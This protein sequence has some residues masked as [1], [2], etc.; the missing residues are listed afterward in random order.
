MPEV[1]V[2]IGGRDYP[3]ACQAGEEDFL[4]S[5]AAMLDAEAAVLLA[6]AARLPETRMLLMAGLMLA[7]KTAGTED[8]IQALEAQVAER[9]A[10]IQAL[11]AE[12][13]EAT[14]PGSASVD[15]SGLRELADRAEELARVAEAS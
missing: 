10:E 7:D 15:L 6:Q 11:R 14:A 2:T 8:Q 3:V 13:A 4:R 1:T 9:D 5:A 12:L